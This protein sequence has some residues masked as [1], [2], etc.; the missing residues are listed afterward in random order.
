MTRL[1]IRAHAVLILLAFA[2]PM[3][4]R[5]EL[6]LIEA[7]W[8]GT[9]E[10][11]REG[12]HSVPG[13]DGKPVIVTVRQQVVYTLDGTTHAATVAS[14]SEQIDMGGRKVPATGEW[15]GSVE[16]GAGFVDDGQDGR[17]YKRGWYLAAH[18]A[19]LVTTVDIPKEVERVEVAPGHYLESPDYYRDTET[20][21]V[22][23]V[24]EGATSLQSLSGSDKSEGLIQSV[25]FGNIPGTQVLSW[26]LRRV[27]ARP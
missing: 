6:K 1:S 14:H 15:A 26:N 19:P 21:P 9:I 23:H 4:A 17:F 22:E 10:V 11:V 3:S 5:A 20:Y 16:A 24:I 7:N 18:R 2:L 8:V 12:V 25:F 27:P 13:G